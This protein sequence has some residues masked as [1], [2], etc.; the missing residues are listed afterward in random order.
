[1]DKNSYIIN[2]ER[3]L[4]NNEQLT[5][6]EIQSVITALRESTKCFQTPYY[7]VIYH[8]EVDNTERKIMDPVYSNTTP[9][10]ENYDLRFDRFELNF[11]RLVKKEESEK[12]DGNDI[13]LCD[14]CTN[15]GC[16]FQ[17]GIVR[18]KCAF[19]IPPTEE[20]ITKV[21]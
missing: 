11:K 20:A 6:V 17:S 2:I 8:D 9:F 18:T 7:E 10:N 12:S 13:N 3:K 15:Y 14:S 4:L 19:Y 5:S 16:E 21:K 1:M